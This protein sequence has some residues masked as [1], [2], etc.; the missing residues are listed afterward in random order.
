[1][2]GGLQIAAGMVQVLN[3][4]YPI[5]MDMKKFRTDPKNEKTE[6]NSALQDKKIFEDLEL[7]Q[8]TQLPPTEEE[9]TRL[10]EMASKPPFSYIHKV[11]GR[12][13]R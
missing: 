13:P 5:P 3:L 11:K 10:N 8:R 7:A 2:A 12:R 4:T 1:M 6:I 9:I